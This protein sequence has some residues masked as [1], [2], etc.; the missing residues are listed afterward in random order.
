MSQLPRLETLPELLLTQ[1]LSGE[2]GTNRCTDKKPLIRA[3]NDYEAIHTWLNEYAHKQTTYQSYRKE[4][5][6]LLLWCVLQAKKPLSS[7]NRDDFDI[8]LAFLD[9]PQPENVWCKKRGGYGVKRGEKGWKPFVGGLSPSAKRTAVSIIKSLMGYLHEARYL[10]SNPL[11]LMRSVK[12]RQQSLEEQKLNIH[13]RILEEDEWH[14]LIQ[15]LD[16]WPQT[17]PEEKSEKIRLKLL[18]GLLFFL[19]LRVNDVST[20]QW[21]AFKKINDLWWFYV[22][23]KG[24]KLGKIPVNNELLNLVIDYRLHFEMPLYPQ[25]E[26]NTPLIV[27]FRNSAKPIG[28]RQ[29][30]QLIKELAKKAAEK[31]PDNLAKQKK[32]GKLS[33]HW[34]RHQFASIQASLGIA[35]EQIQ[36]NMRHISYL[37]TQIYIHLNED[38]RHRALEGI[39]FSYLNSNK[40]DT[41]N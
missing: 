8:Y 19:G 41:E 20:S 38:S 28:D 36:E 31:F 1:D 4:A 35:P 17:T 39:K 30:N 18:V 21:N 37:T 16:K 14:A 34:F 11:V 26:E 7:L 25:A 13:E 9:D 29:I 3:Q 10:D 12:H 33:P 15:T 32:L 23:G 24:D 27:S 22:R 40:K 5:E 2:T 6:R